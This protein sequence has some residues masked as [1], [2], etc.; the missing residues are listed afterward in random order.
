MK[1]SDIKLER[2]TCELGDIKVDK[3][4]TFT[5]FDQEIVPDER[6]F[7]SLYSRFGISGRF[8]NFFDHHEVF[9]RI[10]E[11]S[12][13]GDTIQVTLDTTNETP[14]LLSLCNSK[15][16]LPEMGAI[17]NALKLGGINIDSFKADIKMDRRSTQ[18]VQKAARYESNPNGNNNRRASVNHNNSGHGNTLA[19]E[20]AFGHASEVS[21]DM[22]LNDIH[23]ITYSRGVIRVLA[24]PRANNDFDINGDRFLGRY[25]LD[26]PI[27]GY[28]SPSIYLA[29][30]RQ[31]CTNLSVGLTKTFKSC[32]NLNKARD[33]VE[34][35]GRAMESFND[36]EGYDIIRDRFT[37]AGQSWASINEMQQVY[38]ALINMHNKGFVEQPDGTLITGSTTTSDDGK[39][40]VSDYNPISSPILRRYRH[41]LGDMTK[42]YG[43][44]NLD[45]IPTRRKQ[46][47]PTK[48]T[49][50]DLLNFM[51]EVGT[52]WT[53]IE[54]Q[55]RMQGLVGTFLANKEYDLEGSAVKFADH[56]EMFLADP[57]TKAAA[58]TIK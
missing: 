49:V 50:Y 39:V 14:V 5:L 44:A 1:L 24:M 15:W 38:Q 35:V 58:I 12:D 37:K 47:L 48:C 56:E 25:V 9:Q 22:M 21:A 41:L 26:I 33:Y 16:E 3:D 31:V 55:R 2:Q 8:F 6:F 57:K 18:D 53:N 30:L 29:M 43:I 27:D 23:D 51:T 19:F 52:H 42:M 34:A 32:L 13:K 4:L 45:A 28:G 54:G 40:T 10:K 46:V 7:T 36:D 17:E 11:R 20:G